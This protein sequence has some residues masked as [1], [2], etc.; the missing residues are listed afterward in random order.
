MKRFTLWFSIDETCVGMRYMVNGI[1][2]QA[3]HPDDLIQWIDCGEY[4]LPPDV[5]PLGLTAEQLRPYA[6][7]P[8]NPVIYVGI[9]NA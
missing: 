7:K 5:N 8:D 6:F 3:G 4:V 1:M 2:Y 9:N